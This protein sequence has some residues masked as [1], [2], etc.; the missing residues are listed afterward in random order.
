[1]EADKLSLR[2]ELGKLELRHVTRAVLGN[3]SHQLEQGRH[4]EIQ[5]L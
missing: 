4:L 1:M 5:R 2:E 3:L